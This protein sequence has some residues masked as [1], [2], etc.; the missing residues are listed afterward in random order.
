MQ[1]GRIGALSFSLIY[2]I[3]S[4]KDV[5]SV[6]RVVDVSANSSINSRVSSA[7]F[8]G[9]VSPWSSSM[10]L[11]VLIT[12]SSLNCTSLSSNEFEELRVG[13]LSMLVNWKATRHITYRNRLICSYLTEFQCI[14][15]PYSNLNGVFTT[16]RPLKAQQNHSQV[17]YHTFVPLTK[18]Q[19]R[20]PMP[21]VAILMYTVILPIF[22]AIRLLLIIFKLLPEPFIP[23]YLSYVLKSIPCR[24]NNIIKKYDHEGSM[25][26]SSYIQSKSYQPRTEKTVQ[27]SQYILI[28]SEKD[29]SQIHLKIRFI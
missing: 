5:S 24:Y 16:D 25:V 7:T 3:E 2:S 29:G 9:T 13:V 21:Q 11:S 20:L 23:V 15:L 1:H 17:H 8:S 6:K 4:S 22:Y 14:K 27:K 26:T 18:L 28:L 12:G 10:S 19:H